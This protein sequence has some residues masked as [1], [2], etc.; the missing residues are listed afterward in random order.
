MNLT[1]FCLQAPF[2]LVLFSA[3]TSLSPLAI[4]VGYAAVDT[5]IG[6]L[7]TVITQDKQQ[8]YT[9]MPKLEVEKGIKSIDPWTVAALYLFNP[10]TILSCVS[11]STLIFTNLSI[12]LALSLALK[13]ICNDM[14]NARWVWSGADHD[15]VDR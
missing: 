4:P 14:L 10:L 3:L 2:L 8:V 15:A 9:K 1:S 6:Y 11:K 5:Y 12:V 7:L 13:G